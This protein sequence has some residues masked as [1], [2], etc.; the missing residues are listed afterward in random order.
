[1][2]DIVWSRRAL[3]RGRGGPERHRLPLG[4][5]TDKLQDGRARKAGGT[6]RSARPRCGHRVI[7]GGRDGALWF[8]DRDSSSLRRVDINTDRPD[9]APHVV[10][11]VGR[12]GAGTG[13]VR[14]PRRRSTIPRTCR[15]STTAPWWWPTRAT[16]PC[17]RGHLRRRGHDHL[18]PSRCSTKL[19]DDDLVLE[20]L[21]CG[22]PRRT[23]LGR[24]TRTAATRRN[25]GTSDGLAVVRCR[26]RGPVPAARRAGS[27]RR[28]APGCASEPLDRLAHH[29]LPPTTPALRLVGALP[30]P[31][32]L[33]EAV[34]RRGVPGAA[35]GG[36]Q[37][38]A[39]RGGRALGSTPAIVA[40]RGRARRGC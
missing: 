33:A 30:W 27:P 14:R 15:S 35:R 1:M 29:G 38:P 26:D 22:H 5:L 2:A 11:V 32:A 9:G 39:A 36:A 19:S 21:P 18:R 7:T 24:G 34:R 3:R 12:H 16:T 6:A 25:P 23:T 8:V 4:R 20:K 31:V 28:S 37:R 13:T 40:A 10:T 17:A